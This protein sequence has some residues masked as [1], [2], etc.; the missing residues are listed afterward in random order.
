MSYLNLENYRAYHSNFYN[1]GNFVEIDEM[2]IPVIQLLNKKGYK[3]S[4]CCAGHFLWDLSEGLI[5]KEDADKPPNWMKILQLQEIPNSSKIFAIF[6]SDE[7]R[8]LYISFEYE[9]GKMLFDS[10]DLPSG[11]TWDDI[12]LQCEKD[13]KYTIRYNYNSKEFFKFVRE[14]ITII[15][16]LYYWVEYGL[17]DIK[18]KKEEN[19]MK[20][21]FISVGM[22]GRE[23]Y[24]IGNDIERAKSIIK[25]NATGQ[26]HIIDNYDCVKPDT[27]T[28]RLY[29]LGE[30]VKKLGDCDACFFVKGWENY[31]GCKV[32]MEVCKTYGIEIIL[33]EEL[34]T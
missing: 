14:Q 1:N 29:C 34:E 17:P 24:D 11:F 25:Y 27:L 21:V 16:R 13:V 10:V 6:E 5:Y 31:N 30:A 32:E 2:I 12:D 20:K 26:I 4:F 22:S 28:T 15:E 33:E 3:T 18:N 9:I 23:A 8:S 19:N 7:N